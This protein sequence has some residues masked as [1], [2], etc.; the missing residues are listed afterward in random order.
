MR[1]II[2]FVFF[3]LISWSSVGQ[4]KISIS[5]SN[6]PMISAIEKLEAETNKRFFFNESWIDS[7]SVTETFDGAELDM[8]LN[9]LFEGTS[10]SFYQM[11]DRV[12][13]TDNVVIISHPEI[14]NSFSKEEV[15]VNSIKKGLVFSREYSGFNNDDSDLENAVFEIGN[16]NSMVTGGESTI[17]GYIRNAESNEPIEGALVYV[18]NPFIA[19]IAV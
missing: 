10:I 14:T 3:L 1:Y 4:E 12:I 7:L 5:F 11:D 6:E 2:L 19:A 8:I 16:R 18:Q 9:T 13:L 17:A 15:E